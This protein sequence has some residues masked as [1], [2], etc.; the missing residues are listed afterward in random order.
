MRR[1]VASLLR[2]IA[3]RLHPEREITVHIRPVMVGMDDMQESLKMLAA[4][5][6]A[7]AR[8]GDHLRC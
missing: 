3:N 1:L 6:Q 7:R 2:S 5:E 8:P 4:Y